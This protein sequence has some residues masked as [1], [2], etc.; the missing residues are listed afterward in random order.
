VPTHK[1]ILSDVDGC[2]VSEGVDPF[3][4]ARL[5]EVAAWNRAAIATRD[6]PLLTICTGR[7]QPFA[8]AIC[9]LVA[10][11]E[12]PCVAENGAW[13][14]H[15][16]TNAYTLDPGITRDDLNAVNALSAWIREDFGPRGVTQQPGKTASVSLYHDDTPLLLGEVLE[17]VREGVASRGWPFRVTHTERYVNCDLH[18]VSKAV[19]IDRWMERTGLSTE[20]LA[21][22]GDAASDLFIRERVAWFACPAN[23]VDQIKQ[24]A[25]YVSSE[26]EV[27]GV[28]DILDR[29]R[30]R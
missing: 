15:P 17:A 2:L 20:Q 4:V 24:H 27:A 9:R 21:G 3:D 28:L 19:A 14:Y 22:I 29:L 8:E 11:T 23:A 30:G 7:P 25:D 18:H 12:L 13:I 5:S 16:A 1:A 6:R 26:P 10:N